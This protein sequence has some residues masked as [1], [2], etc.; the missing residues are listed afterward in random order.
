VVL[1]LSNQPEVALR[2]VLAIGPKVRGFKPDRGRRILRTIKIRNTT[3][4]GAEIKLSVPCR[5]NLQHVKEA[6]RYEKR[7]FEDKI[8][9]HFSPR[10]P[11]LLPDIS[12]GYC[13]TTL[14]DG[15]GMIR[16]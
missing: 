9:G 11:A 1:V 7:Y 13:H 8:H 6:N 5:K 4:F 16:T 12:A 3:S 15:S 10:F 2:S 14:V